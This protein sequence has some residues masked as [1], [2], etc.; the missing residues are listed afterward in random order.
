[1]ARK[2]NKKDSKVIESVIL[3]SLNIIK[4]NIEEDKAKLLLRLIISGI[5][6]HYFLNP[7]DLIDMGFLRFEK[8][9]DKEELFKVTIIK[10]KEYGVVNAETLWKFYKGELQQEAEFKQVLENFLEE[11]INYSQEQEINI[12]HLTSQI[13]RKKRRK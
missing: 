4:E 7:D 2:F 13:D 11:L 5:A 6:Y 3:E 8:S 12:T 9:P 10:D 1:M